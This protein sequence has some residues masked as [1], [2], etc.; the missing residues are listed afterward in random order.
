MLYKTANQSV[1]ILLSKVLA[2][3]QEDTAGN[4]RPSEPP[5]TQSKIH[6]SL[7]PFLNGIRLPEDAV[8]AGSAASFKRSSA[9]PLC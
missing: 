1:A 3:L 6:S 9:A 8:T 7:R 5:V 4:I 2:D